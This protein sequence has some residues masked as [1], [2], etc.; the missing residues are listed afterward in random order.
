MPVLT[1][2]F[3]KMAYISVAFIVAQ[4]LM[5]F[6][7]M[8]AY[9]SGP[10]AAEIE[11]YVRARIDMGENVGKFFR[12][13]ERPQFGPEGGPSS[14]TLQKL[15]MEINEF[16]GNILSKHELTIE[17]Y[18]TR[19]PKV[20]ADEAGVNSFLDAHPDLKKRYEAIPKNPMGG[21]GGH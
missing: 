12:N 5:P 11:Q 14:E 16:I 4:V 20:F 21:R 13:R 9:A 10:S 15:T 17:K 18:Q 1:I 6:T 2:R 7:T 8:S 3:M 19:S